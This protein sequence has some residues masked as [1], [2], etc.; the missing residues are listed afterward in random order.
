MPHKSL[1]LST[2]LAGAS[3]VGLNGMLR[4]RK[5]GGLNIL[6]FHGFTDRIHEGMQN[7]SGLHLHADAFA[8]ICGRLARNHTVLHLHEA[9][10]LIRA[11][12]PLPRRAIVLTFDDGYASIH[13]IALPILRRYH[14]PAT[15]FIATDFVHNGAWLWPDRVEYALHRSKAGALEIT[16]GTRRLQLPLNSMAERTAALFALCAALKCIPQEQ[17]YQETTRVEEALGCSLADD[18][19]PPDI[20][21]PL[22][23]PQARQLADSG[24]VTLG[25]HTHHHRILGRCTLETARW[26]IETSRRLIEENT[27]VRPDCFAYPNGKPGDHNAATRQLLADLDYRCALTTEEGVNPT[28]SATDLLA[29]RRFGQRPGPW[30]L[31]ALTSGTLGLLRGLRQHLRRDRRTHPA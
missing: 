19:V 18:P 16:I 1:L 27:G 3:V 17:L 5:S 6:M 24:L 15:V 4:L 11:G 21:R 14:L 23:W 13:R 7:A 10:D 12:S 20:Y 28:G 30:H 8:K 26:E 31:D 2:I 22:S 9:A 25:A 29:M